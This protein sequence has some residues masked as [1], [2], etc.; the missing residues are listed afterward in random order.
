MNQLDARIMLF[1]SLPVRRLDRLSLQ[2]KLDEIGRIEDEAHV[3]GRWRSSVAHTSRP[4][5]L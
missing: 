4:W 3:D 1:T 5:H 2:K